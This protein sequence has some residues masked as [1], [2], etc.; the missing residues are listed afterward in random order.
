MDFTRVRQETQDLK[1]LVEW[2]VIQAR[3]VRLDLLDIQDHLAER[4]KYVDLICITCIL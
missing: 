4:F 1:D 3:K 2:Q